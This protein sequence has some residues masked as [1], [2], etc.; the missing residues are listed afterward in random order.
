MRPAAFLISISISV[1]CLQRL[2]SNLIEMWYRM[3]SANDK[4]NV[5]VYIMVHY[6][7]PAAQLDLIT[8]NFIFSSVKSIVAFKVYI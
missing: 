4:V 2:K 3:V 6:R 7:K 5:N 1:G 8:Y